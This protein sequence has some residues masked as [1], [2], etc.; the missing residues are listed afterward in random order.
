M[1]ARKATE[2][3]RQFYLS[4]TANKLLTPE[5]TADQFLRVLIEKKQYV[6]A[7]RVLSYALPKEKAIAWASLCARQFSAANPSDVSRAALEA[8]D[9]W[10]SEQSEENRRAAMKVAERAEFGTPAGSA[11]LAVFF[12]GGSI[13]PPEAPFTAPEPNML[14]SSVFN[15]VMVAVLSKEPDKAEEKYNLFLAKGQELAAKAT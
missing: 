11:A 3:C 4:E 9:K 6:D 12:S 13:A 5:L 2:I 7:V 14:P 8:V 15:A 10:M 1:E